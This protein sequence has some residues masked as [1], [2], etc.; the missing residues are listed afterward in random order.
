[1]TIAVLQE[2]IFTDEITAR[3]WLEGRV[4]AGWY[5]LPALRLDPRARDQARRF[6]AS[7]GPLPGFRSLNRVTLGVNDERR[8]AKLAD[9]GI[10]GKRLT[11]RLP[12]SQSHTTQ[13]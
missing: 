3:E 5:G 6:E 1:M 7:S 2:P 9:D 8:A 13:N 12:H 10:V 11:Y 4:W